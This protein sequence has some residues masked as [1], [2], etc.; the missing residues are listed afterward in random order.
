MEDILEGDL[1]SQLAKASLFQ[2]FIADA[3]ISIV[4][5][6]EYERT[7]ARYG[8]RGTRYV[9]M[10]AG[11]VSQNIYLQVESLG[12]GTVAVGAFRDEE[13]SK[14]LNLPERHRPLY[15]MPIGYTTIGYT[16]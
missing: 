8:E 5:T 13:V 7:T 1:R 4:I 14:V 12:L 2:M 15:V 9:H 3:P 10:E 6:G 16:K 11:H